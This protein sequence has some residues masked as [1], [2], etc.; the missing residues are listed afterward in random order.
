MPIAVVAAACGSTHTAP[1]P[2]ERHLVYIAG[3][4]PASA[5]VWIADVTGAHPRMLGHGSVAV[6]SPDGRTVAV[7]RPD[8]IHLV[9]SS[10]KSDRRLTARHLQPRAWSSDGETLIA[11]RSTPSAP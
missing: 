11:T 9:S 6:L 10:G 5:S 4:T 3:D 7:S 1:K 8:G 2:A